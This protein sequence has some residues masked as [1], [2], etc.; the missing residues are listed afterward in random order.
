MRIY[1]S[2]WN[3]PSIRRQMISASAVALGGL[4]IFP[5][6]MNKAD[7]QQTMAEENGN[8]KSIA[9]HQ[10][11]DFKAAPQ[12]IYEVLLDARQFSA[13]SGAPAT[14][15]REPGGAFS[16]FGGHITGRNIELAENRRIVQAWRAATWD[17]GIYSI[18]RFELTAQAPGTHLI[19]D[20]TGF[21][22]GKKEHLA[23]GWK[24][25]YW[26]NLKKYLG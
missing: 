23:A 4:A 20:H 9:L 3:A 7:A 19:F 24:E 26:E 16:L 15:N 11:I 5:A 6:M 18:A 12:R 22:E 2:V 8:D 17:E 14:I 25:H 21:P 1:T 10:E 13:F